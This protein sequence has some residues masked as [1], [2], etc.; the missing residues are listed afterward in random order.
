[1]KTFLIALLFG[2]VCLAEEEAPQH[3]R[4]TIQFIEVPHPPLTELLGGE[5]TGGA[6]IHAKVM[7]LAKSG[8]AKILETSMVVCGSGHKATVESTL[9]E[10]YATEYE[11]P[12]FEPPV[13]FKWFDPQTRAIAAFETKNTGITLEIEPTIG[14]N[15][16]IVDLRFMPEFV[17]RLRLENWM[18]H[19]DEWGDASFGMPTYEKW[20]ADTS[21]TL[22]SGKPELASVITPESQPP[23]P[24]VSRRILLFVRADVIAS[25][26]KP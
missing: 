1:M 3:A 24:G 2:G 9:E 17:Q 22:Q 26:M 4:V 5:E 7:A 13:D 12:G 10:I 20:A 16:A 25:P 8:E 11:P 23:T 6:A 21:L 14:S 15:N 18:E 19:K